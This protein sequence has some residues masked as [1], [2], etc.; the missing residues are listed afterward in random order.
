LAGEQVLQSSRFSSKAIILRMAG[1]YGPGRIPRSADLVAGRPIDVPEHGWLN[2]IHVDDAARIVLLAEQRA[3]PPQTYV[4]SDGHPVQRADYYRELARLLN[5]PSPKFIA[6][7]GDSPAAERAASD[8]RVN[9][10]KM[11][12][13]LRPALSYPH[14]RAGLAGI[15]SMGAAAR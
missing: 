8:K 3:L 12:A 14:Y 10:Q 6:S 2:L 9:P 15:V 5:A 11:F 4:V 1:I 7:P 13:E